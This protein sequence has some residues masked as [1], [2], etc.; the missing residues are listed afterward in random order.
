MMERA[1]FGASLRT[2]ATT[3]AL[4]YVLVLGAAPTAFA[5]ADAKRGG[6]LTIG[7]PAQVLGFDIAVTKTS[8]FEST[9]VGGMIFGTLFGLDA[10]DH[11]YPSTALSAE[12]SKDGTV[13]T[14][15]LRPGVRFSDGSPY[16]ANAVAKH[17]TRILDPERSQAY[18]VYVSPFKEVVAVDPLTVEFR[19]KHAWPAFASWL[20]F[21]N[22]FNWVMPAQYEVS[23]EKDMNRKPIGAGPYMLQEWNQDGG[24]VLVRNPHYWNPDA[25]HFDKI[26]VKFVPDEN[27]RYA[28]V[29]NGDI[30]IT[31][32]T[33]QQV[34]DAR[35]IP[36]LQVIKQQGTGAFTLQFN[37]SAPPL[38][39]V[40]VRQALAYAVDRNAE[41]NVI[42]SGEA[43]MAKSLWG[44]G[45]SWHC[46]V[47]YPE[48]DPAKA[49]ALLESY[50]KPVKITLQVPAYPIG[51]LI[52]ELYQSFWQKVGVETEIVQTQIG[53]AYVGPVFAGKYQATLWDSPDLP[54]P[55]TQVYAVL[56]S[57]SG[58][59]VTRTNDPVLDE[60]LD[61][62]RVSME[63]VARRAA[64]CDFSRELNKFVP[65]LLRNQ[66]DYYAMA[67]GKLRGITHLRFGRY[68]PADGWWEK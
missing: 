37:T 67:N 63:P 1:K 39:D 41:K 44:A 8:T 30:D 25:Q 49:K 26:A 62:G 10:T 48:Y 42:L 6:T 66:H 52:G 3:L 57:G 12:A 43:D 56:H 31:F 17:W 19:M 50:G 24:M 35:K 51:V 20:S 46:E 7:T 9:M 59:N 18:I 65:F 47:D 58:A 61:R 5:A 13:W 4:A 29:K 33:M 64:Y 16:D 53:P 32:G 21:N 60:A 2:A 15:K 36:S 14:I 38:D 40:R 11:A 55:D 28:A 68:W 34:Q 45:S 23:A 22:A 54:D 27:S